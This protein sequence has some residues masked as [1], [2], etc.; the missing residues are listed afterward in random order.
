MEESLDWERSGGLD[1][2]EQ[3]A[4]VNV[5]EVVAELLKRY[6]LLNTSSCSQDFNELTW[7]TLLL[8]LLL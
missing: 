3:R 5:S 7:D 2:V 4:R 6:V 8:L 1:G